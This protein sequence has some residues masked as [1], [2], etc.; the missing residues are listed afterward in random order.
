VAAC[1]AGDALLIAGKGHET[2]QILND[3][4][5]DFDDRVIALEALRAR[6]FGA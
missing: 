4:T 5:V 3:R 6:G 2:Y 1:E